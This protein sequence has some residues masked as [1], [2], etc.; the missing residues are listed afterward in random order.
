MKKIS[1]RLFGYGG[2]SHSNKTNL[3]HRRETFT[4]GTKNDM[5]TDAHSGFSFQGCGLDAITCNTDSQYS[6]YLFP[7][8]CV[9][10]HTLGFYTRRQPVV[11]GLSSDFYSISSYG[12]L[13]SAE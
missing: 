7:N 5:H 10:L 1:P 3:T 6:L 12:A 2:A 4:Y 13:P 11:V 9:G 8:G